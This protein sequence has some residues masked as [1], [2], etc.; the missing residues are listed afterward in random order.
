MTQGL[1]LSSRGSTIWLQD[2]ASHSLPTLRQQCYMSI[3]DGSP[4]P[5][6]VIAVRIT[7]RRGQCWVWRASMALETLEVTGQWAS[8]AKRNPSDN[9]HAH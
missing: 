8:P 1:F 5:G 9:Q 3:R 4:G 2:R 7:S 6:Q